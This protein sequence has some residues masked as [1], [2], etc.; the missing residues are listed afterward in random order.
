MKKILSILFAVMILFQSGVIAAEKPDYEK[1]GQ[2][3]IAVVKADYP[4]EAVTEYQYL[5]RKKLMNDQVE[6][7]FLFNVTEN[8][9]KV[10]VTVKVRHSLA[11][12]KMLNLTVE[13]IT[14]Q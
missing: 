11:N 4:G 3:A 10:D 6:D 2:I 7:G 5:G 12:N 1:Y 14:G 9:K 13:E 8:G